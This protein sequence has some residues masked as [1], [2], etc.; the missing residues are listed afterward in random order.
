MPLTRS[1]PKWQALRNYCGGWKLLPKFEFKNIHS[2]IN[3]NRVSIK[4]DNP[5]MSARINELN[6]NM[7]K[8]F[9]LPS[10]SQSKW[11]RHENNFII[12]ISSVSKK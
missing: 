8:V 4:L 2:A 1:F 12:K 9:N 11:E 5:E 10:I 7:V 3:L 6:D